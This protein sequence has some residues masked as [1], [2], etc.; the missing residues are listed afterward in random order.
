M[1]SWVIYAQSIVSSKWSISII[2][3]YK[4]CVFVMYF[5]RFTRIQLYFF[6]ARSWLVRKSVLNSVILVCFHMIPLRFKRAADH[7][8][9]HSESAHQTACR[10]VMRQHNRRI[11]GNYTVHR[12]TNK[13][14][15]GTINFMCRWQPYALQDGGDEISLFARVNIAVSNSSVCG[16]DN[17]SRKIYSGWTPGSIPDS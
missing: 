8:L 13:I 9:F 11:S 6:A 14:Y 16:V 10:Q 4:I 15:I 2:L 5:L 1:F 12:Y 3:D 7:A 17:N